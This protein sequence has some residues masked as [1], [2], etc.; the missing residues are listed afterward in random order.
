MLVKHAEEALSPERAIVFLRDAT[1]SIFAIRYQ[2]EGNN[3]QTVEV[4]FG[5]SDDLAQWLAKV[6]KKNKSLLE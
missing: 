3:L 2:R 1:Q 4:P 6:A 5:L